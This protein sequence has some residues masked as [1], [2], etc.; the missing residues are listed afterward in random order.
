MSVSPSAPS[1]A[2]IGRI[3]WECKLANISRS[4]KNVDVETSA[5]MP[6]DATKWIRNYF[7]WYFSM[8]TGNGMAKLLDYLGSTEGQ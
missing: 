1:L 8:L 7:K 6:G 2:C 5:D 4:L 3:S